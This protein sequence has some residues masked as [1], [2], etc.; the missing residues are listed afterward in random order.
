MDTQI[1]RLK[2]DIGTDLKAIADIYAALNRYGTTPT[3]VHKKAQALE[4]IYQADIERFL[5]FLDSLL[6]IEA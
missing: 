1:R 3:L 5:T 2:A 4:P 6:E